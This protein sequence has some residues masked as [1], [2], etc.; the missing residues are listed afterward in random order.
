ML[1]NYKWNYIPKV[2][3]PYCRLIQ[4]GGKS[5]YFPLI[6]LYPLGFI[7]E[8]ESGWL[9]FPLK[10]QPQKAVNPSNDVKA[11]RKNWYV[12]SYF[13]SLKWVIVR[14]PK[15]GYKFLLTA[16]GLLLGQSGASALKEY[17][18]HEFALC[19]V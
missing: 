16:E 17:K 13:Y 9:Y 11:P 18:I 8:T 4:G 6:M 14:A 5:V 10:E 1:N 3:F 2:I 15:S 19:G 7:V 12:K